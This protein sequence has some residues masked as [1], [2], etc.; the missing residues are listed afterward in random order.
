MNAAGGFAAPG[1]IARNNPVPGTGAATRARRK[2]RPRRSA[3][4]GQETAAMTHNAADPRFTWA[5]LERWTGLG[6]LRPEQLTAIREHLAEQ[7][8]ARPGMAPPPVGPEPR[9]RFDLVTVA[10]Y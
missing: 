4:I 6:L 8:D 7:H 10:Y 1:R 2:M 5:D 9:A 3:R